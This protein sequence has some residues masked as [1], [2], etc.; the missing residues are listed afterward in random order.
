MADPNDANTG[1]SPDNGQFRTND[2]R[3]AGHPDHELYHGVRQHALELFNKHNA[4]VSVNQLEAVTAAIIANSKR[5][6]LAQVGGL[7][8]CL[9]PQTQQPDPTF[10][11]AA[12]ANGRNDFPPHNSF[13]DTQQALRQSAEEIYQQQRAVQQ[14][15]AA[16]TQRDTHERHNPPDRQGP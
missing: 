4:H 14:Q 6:Q 16:Q 15:Q 5:D 2:P 8:A 9:H 1:A 12:Y 3:D 7:E 10:R 11:I 13:T